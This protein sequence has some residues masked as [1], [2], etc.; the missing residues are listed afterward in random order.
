[1]RGFFKKHHTLLGIH[2]R[3]GLCQMEHMSL[4]ND[5]SLLLWPGNWAPCGNEL[6]CTIWLSF[7]NMI[8][9]RDLRAMSLA[10]LCFLGAGAEG[11]TPSLFVLFMITYL[12]SWI[13]W[14]KKSLQR[15][16]SISFFFRSFYWVS[17]LIFRNLSNT[18]KPLSKERLYLWSLLCFGVTLTFW[19]RNGDNFT[20][21]FFCKRDSDRYICISGCVS[22]G[23]L[24]NSRWWKDYEIPCN[25]YNMSFICLLLL[26]TTLGTTSNSYFILGN[27][28]SIQDLFVLDRK[29]RIFPPVQWMTEVLFMKAVLSGMYL[30][31]LCAAIGCLISGRSSTPVWLTIG[32]KTNKQRR[33]KRDKVHQII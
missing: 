20:P 17:F 13:G 14:L 19:V 2:N 15:T 23:S 25:C 18:P 7:P 6:F 30:I 31:K 29:F 27:N 8:C 32:V 1:M 28:S 24:G 4:R 12:L 9:W 10:V 5:L 21:W 33:A 3:N 22:W 26:L 11:F 16:G